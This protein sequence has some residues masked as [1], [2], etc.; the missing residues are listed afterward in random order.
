MLMRR[1]VHVGTLR[2][3]S[4][5]QCCNHLVGAKELVRNRRG[6]DSRTR[7]VWGGGGA[8]VL[9][10]ARTN[11]HAHSRLFL[12]LSILLCVNP[13]AES[14]ASEHCTNVCTTA[15]G[16]SFSCFT[17]FQ[18][19]HSHSRYEPWRYAVPNYKFMFVSE[20][21]DGVDAMDNVWCMRRFP[22]H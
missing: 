21:P 4:H 17:Y 9:R 20:P 13:P 2:L 14:A 7:D 3:S 22:G 12:G 16:R 18:D 8:G 5:V 19:L 1:R 11:H 6:Q 10:V 15:K